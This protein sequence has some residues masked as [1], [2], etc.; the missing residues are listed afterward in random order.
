MEMGAETEEGGDGGVDEGGA[1]W[2]GDEDAQSTL[3]GSGA[4]EAL[5]LIGGD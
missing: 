5:D 1:D 4:R 3:V 2:E